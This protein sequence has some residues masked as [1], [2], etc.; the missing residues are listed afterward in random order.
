M[1]QRINQPNNLRANY[2]WNE[3]TSTLPVNQPTNKQPK[4]STN[5]TIYEPIDST[6]QA[7]EQTSTRPVN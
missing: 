4:E 7:R 6:N 5:K 3:Q 2:S 1:T